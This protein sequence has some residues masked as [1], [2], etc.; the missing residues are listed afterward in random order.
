[1]IS[2]FFRRFLSVYPAIIIAIGILGGALWA[3]IDAF[4]FKQFYIAQSEVASIL[5][6]IGNCYALFCIAAFVAAVI[7]LVRGK[8]FH[9]LCCFVAAYT[10]FA[11]MFL[12]SA[13]LA[14]VPL[15]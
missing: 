1:M 10:L 3:S 11:S 2:A 6:Y 4:A 15:S 5:V 9:A 7:L 8:G 12:S 13:F 14:Y